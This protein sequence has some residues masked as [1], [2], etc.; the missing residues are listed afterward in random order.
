MKEKRPKKQ[1]LCIELCVEKFLV[2]SLK[3]NAGAEAKKQH[4][5]DKAAQKLEA[6]DPHR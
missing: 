5:N 1:N 4:E 2:R 6:S 3:N